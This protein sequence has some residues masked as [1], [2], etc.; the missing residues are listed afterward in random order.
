MVGIVATIG[1]QAPYR[2]ASLQQGSG[3][4]DVVDI[5]G[6]QQQDT[7][8]A[9][10]VGQRMGLTRLATDMYDPGRQE[11]PNIRSA[12][13]NDVVQCMKVVDSQ[14]TASDIDNAGLAPDREL[15]AYDLA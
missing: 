2:V 10:T 14:A 4:A 5:A 11:V 15:A 6:G 13:G 1:N 7:W 3:D 9:L 8:P 12:A